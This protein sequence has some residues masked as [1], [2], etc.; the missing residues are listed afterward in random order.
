M[1]ELNIDLNLNAYSGIVS[2]VHLKKMKLNSSRCHSQLNCQCS[3]GEL[4]ERYK[5]FVS[6]LA[7]RLLR[8]QPYLSKMLFISFIGKNQQIF[9][10]IT[11]NRTIN[12]EPNSLHRQKK[13]YSI[14]NSRV[15][16]LKDKFYLGTEERK[17]LLK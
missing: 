15:P 17:I 12:S 4:P 13:F 5:M 11:I 8:K 9:T 2:T 3:R 16:I 10:Y 7:L 6:S 1:N 14:N